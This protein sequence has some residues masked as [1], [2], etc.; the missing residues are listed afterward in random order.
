MR[1]LMPGSARKLGLF[2]QAAAMRGGIPGAFGALGTSIPTPPCG[3]GYREV[4]ASNGQRICITDQK[5]GGGGT[6]ILDSIKLFFSPETTA[7][8]GSQA[9]AAN[10]ALTVS[11]S[12]EARALIDGSRGDAVLNP[13]QATFATADPTAGMLSVGSGVPWPLILGGVAVVLVGVVVL[14]NR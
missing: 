5:A 10:P 6:S 14:K 2:A 11:F 3:S 9:V 4:V 7:A 13:Q 8:Q 12:P 1:Y